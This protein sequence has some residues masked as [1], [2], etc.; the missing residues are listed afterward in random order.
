M[1]LA[2]NIVLLLDLLSYSRS[3][4]MRRAD[5]C[6]RSVVSFYL[7]AERS[8]ITSDTTTSLKPTPTV[9][10]NIAAASKCW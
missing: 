10:Q 2:Q 4:F 8:V 3:S 5:R 1:T 7:S 6:P 9:R